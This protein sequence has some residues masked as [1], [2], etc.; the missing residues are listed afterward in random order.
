MTNGIEQDTFAKLLMTPFAVGRVTV[1]GVD[2]I[3]SRSCVDQMY[4]H[5]M[6]TRDAQA[7]RRI[8]WRKMKMKTVEEL[9][10][11]ASDAPR[12]QVLATRG[13]VTFHLWRITDG[14]RSPVCGRAKKYTVTGETLE[15][16]EAAIKLLTLEDR[17]KWCAETAQRMRA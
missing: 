9:V 16:A 15:L 13:G 5:D 3:I 8:A 10:E 7:K 14:L 6:Q 11:S 17:C 1:E 12:G 2:R 4:V